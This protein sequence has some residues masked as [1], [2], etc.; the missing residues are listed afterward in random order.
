MQYKS[1]LAEYLDMRPVRRH[2][3]TRNVLECRS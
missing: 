1:A 2:T 3:P